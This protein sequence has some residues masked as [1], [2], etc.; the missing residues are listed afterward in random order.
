MSSTTNVQNL[1]TNV[2]RPTFVFANGVYQTK[3]E[4]TNI[5]SVSAN[6]VYGFNGSFGDAS[7]N[8]YIGVEAGN[9]YTLL[10]TSANS[11]NTFVGKQAGQSTTGLVNS[12]LIGYRA[13]ATSTT[14][15]SNS[16][17][18][19]AT[20]KSAC[21]PPWWC[22]QTGRRCGRRRAGL[23]CGWRSGL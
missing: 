20:S 4:L 12:V 10:A 23:A 22:A 2:F 9:P 8:V 16:V 15:S 5:D 13:G 19:G 6:T 18:I 17:S 1:L 11:N 14:T 7:G 21:S 3:L